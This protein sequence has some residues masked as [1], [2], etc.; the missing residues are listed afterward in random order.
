[1]TRALCQSAVHTTRQWTK[2]FCDEPDQAPLLVDL[3]NAPKCPAC[4]G[5]LGG[6]QTL[7]VDGSVGRH[8][9][10]SRLKSAC[11]HFAD[12]QSERVQ[13]RSSSE[14]LFLHWPL[15]HASW[16]PHRSRIL[17]TQEASTTELSSWMKVSSLAKPRSSNCS[18]AAL[19]IF[20]AKSGW[21][22]R[23]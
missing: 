22:L 14:H 5:A 15:T 6:S 18:W 21:N 1:M 16:K 4:G 20:S 8:V 23:L 2:C 10:P 13:Q 9:L 11:R 17:N 7:P 3:A 12:S 19:N